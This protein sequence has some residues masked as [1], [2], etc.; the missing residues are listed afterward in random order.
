MGIS[1]WSAIVVANPHP[2]EEGQHLLIQFGF[3]KSEAG[4]PRSIVLDTPVV[5]VLAISLPRLLDLGLTDDGGTA[6]AAA[7]E[8]AAVG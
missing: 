7:D 8:F 6:V 4:V 1:G 5:N 3:R 2:G